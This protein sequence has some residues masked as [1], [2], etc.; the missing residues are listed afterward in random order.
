MLKHLLLSL[1]HIYTFERMI[2]M[3][4]VT[5]WSFFKKKGLSDC[6]V[7]GLMGNLYAE[8]CIRDR[9]SGQDEEDEDGY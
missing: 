6:G 1:I 5:I 9:Y 3:S 4:E 2:F 7:A 8:M